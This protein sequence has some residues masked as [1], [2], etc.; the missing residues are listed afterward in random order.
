M[1]V[2]KIKG[3]GITRRYQFFDPILLPLSINGKQQLVYAYE[4]VI[5]ITGVHA[6]YVDPKNVRFNIML[7]P[8][9]FDV[10]ALIEMLNVP[11]TIDDADGTLLTRLTSINKKYFGEIID[12]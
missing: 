5:E 7:T 9:K 4:G 11:T 6:I 10:Y 12:F 2:N 3:E 8:S 1:R